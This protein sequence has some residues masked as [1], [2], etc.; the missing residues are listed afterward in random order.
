MAR[1][2]P[3]E[4]LMSFYKGGMK[5]DLQSRLKFAY[6]LMSQTSIMKDHYEDHY[7]MALRWLDSIVHRIDIE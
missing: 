4:A 2:N 1:K 5:G 7:R 6:Q 3:Q